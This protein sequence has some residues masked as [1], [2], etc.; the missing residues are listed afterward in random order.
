MPGNDYFPLK[1]KIVTNDSK[2]R[3]IALRFLFKNVR[4]IFYYDEDGSNY[5]K[6]MG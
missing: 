4:S 6:T 2:A 1:T 3:K 5:R